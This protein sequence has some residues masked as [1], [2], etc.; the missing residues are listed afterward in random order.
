MGV[1]SGLFD[2]KIGHTPRPSVVRWEFSV[3]RRAV[4]LIRF[5]K[6]EGEPRRM[7]GA[8]QNVLF[9]IGLSRERTVFLIER[10]EAEGIFPAPRT[11]RSFVHKCSLLVARS[12]CVASP[13][14]TPVRNA[15]LGVPI[16]PF[17]SRVSV[18]AAQSSTIMRCGL[19]P[20]YRGQAAAMRDPWR[21]SFM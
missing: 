15:Y 12:G 5:F 1:S 7:E 4:V 2:V 21:G 13:P 8:V 16:P 17:C 3:D 14:P 19:E 18:L 20:L 9:R 10:H 6:P 11:F